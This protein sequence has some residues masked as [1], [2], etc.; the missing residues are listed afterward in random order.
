[1]ALDR[2]RDRSLQKSYG[3][4]KTILLRG[5]N[6]NAFE[7]CQRPALKAHSLSGFQEGPRFSREAGSHGSL[8][9]RDLRIL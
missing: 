7:T 4:D 6:E 1:V 8:N 5:S 3:N 9:G 2:H